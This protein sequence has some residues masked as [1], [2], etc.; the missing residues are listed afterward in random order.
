MKHQ[1]QDSEPILGIISQ[2]Y[3]LTKTMELRQKMRDRALLKF[4]DQTLKGETFNDLIDMLWEMLPKTV[5]REI[6]YDSVRYLAGVKLT[7]SVLDTVCWRLAGNVERL[8]KRRVV[9]PWS[10]QAFPEWVPAQITRVRLRRGGKQGRELGYELLFVVLA[11][12][13]CTLEI[14]Q[15]WSF[16]KCRYLSR[17]K[18]PQGNGF[19]FTRPPGQSKRSSPHQ[20]MDARQ[21]VTLRLMLLIDPKLSDEGPDFKDIAFSSAITKW[22]HEL[23][24]YRARLQ[25]EYACPF[26]VP[27][28]QTCY[29]CPV[30]LDHCRAATHNKTYE[31]RPCAQCQSQAASFDPENKTAKFCVSCTEHNVYFPPEEKNDDDDEDEE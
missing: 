6:V 8:S 21:L 19:G 27:L 26:E 12:T 4:R 15:W 13:S 3:Q 25:P 17:Y 30:G 14:R 1:P 7:A 28:P 22:N 16:H 9:P 11:G 29:E 10:R 24:K 2:R 23:Q 18:D 5:L 31:A 20:Y